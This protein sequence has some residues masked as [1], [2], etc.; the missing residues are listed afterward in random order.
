MEKSYSG[1]LDCYNTTYPIASDVMP[2]R[3]LG[4]PAAGM[5]SLAEAL[6]E[7][8]VSVTG[9]LFQNNLSKMS[10]SPTAAERARMCWDWKKKKKKRCMS[11]ALDQ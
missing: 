1:I 10:T 3:K 11:Q 7:W 2:Q 4:F 6:N 5:T 9:N 8:H